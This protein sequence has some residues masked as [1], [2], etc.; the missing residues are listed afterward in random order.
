MLLFELGFQTTASDGKTKLHWEPTSLLLHFNSSLGATSRSGRLFFKLFQPLLQVRKLCLH[1]CDFFLQLVRFVHAGSDHLLYSFH[2][3][4]Y[5]TV[6]LL[7]PL[8]PLI[9]GVDMVENT[10]EL[11]VVLTQFL[12]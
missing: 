3:M 8:E 11:V 1:R 6:L 7:Q 4:N 9:K 5:Q 2:P 10:P 12:F